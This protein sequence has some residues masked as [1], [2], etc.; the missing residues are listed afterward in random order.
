[1]EYVQYL[2][3]DLEIGAVVFDSDYKINLPKLYRAITYLK[4]PDVHFISGATDRLVPFS[5]GV[6]GLGKFA[7]PYILLT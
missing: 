3:D 7:L 5:P 2:Q 1:M 4:R 6:I